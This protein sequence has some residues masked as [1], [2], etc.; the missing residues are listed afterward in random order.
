MWQPVLTH[1]LIQR[2]FLGRKCQMYVIFY[3]WYS[4][5]I[6]TPSVNTDREPI[7]SRSRKG[8]V[9]QTWT[10]HW[11]VTLES[12]D[13]CQMIFFLV[14]SV[15]E[16]MTKRKTR[17]T[18]VLPW[19]KVDRG[20]ISPNT[21]LENREMRTIEREGGKGNTEVLKVKRVR[22]GKVE[23]KCMNKRDVEVTT[24]TTSIWGISGDFFWE[25]EDGTNWRTRNG[26]EHHRK[27]WEWNT[28]K[29]A[30]LMFSG[31]NAKLS[32]GWRSRCALDRG[33][34]EAKIIAM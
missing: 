24:A 3:G 34:A 15:H 11:L 23:I 17:R 29:S 27:W 2:S 28:P 6:W 13:L 19:L 5:R 8:N 16:K 7:R 21:N 12:S 31:R 30:L 18:Q 10:K 14:N 22:W 1:K 25:G 33:P 9:D 26:W 4:M 20:I 32:S